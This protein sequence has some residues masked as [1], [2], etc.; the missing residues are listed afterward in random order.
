MPVSPQEGDHEHKIAFEQCLLFAIS[1][2][3]SAPLIKAS[4]TSFPV[5]F[6]VT[7]QPF[8]TFLAGLA[9]FLWQCPDEEPQSQCPFPDSP[10]ASMSEIHSSISPVSSPPLRSDCNNCSSVSPP[11]CVS[12]A[13]HDCYHLEL[14]HCTKIPATPDDGDAIAS[15][16][17]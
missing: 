15:E 7:I 8:A 3:N 5:T 10:A 4:V 13:P 12:F 16:M 14:R 11:H 17:N 1:K 6:F 2:V 9:V